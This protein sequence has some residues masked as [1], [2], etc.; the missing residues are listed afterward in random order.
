MR[1]SPLLRK[2]LPTPVFQ[3]GYAVKTSVL[4]WKHLNI[5]RG[6]FKSAYSGRVADGD[7]QP[8]PWFTY[9][10]VDFL[11]RI[12]F[13]GK[14]VFEYGCGYSSLWWGQEV[15]TVDAVDDNPFWISSIQKQVPS[16]VALMLRE[17]EQA[18]VNAIAEKGATYD[19]VVVDGSFR[20][21]CASKA[22]DHL[23]PGGMIILDNPDM[24]PDAAHVLDQT[25]MIRVDFWGFTPIADWQSCTA[26]YLSAHWKWAR[27]P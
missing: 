14:R 1:A 19:V 27:K 22:C 6:H 2:W 10:A 12:D 20:A 11:K 23:V 26:V 13:S 8:I 9:P 4:T 15:E 17:G 3:F 21:D 16:N 5:D 7:G 18:Y 25:D 24:M